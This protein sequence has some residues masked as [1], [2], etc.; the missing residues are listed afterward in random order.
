MTGRIALV[1]GATQGLGLAL[2][3]G[4]MHRLGSDDTVYLSGRDLAK[5]EAAAQ[6]ITGGAATLMAERLDVTDDRACSALSASLKARH[7]G[8]DIVISN[9][10]AR[11]A[12]GV[13]DRDQVRS[14]INT[15]NHGNRRMLAHFLPLLRK[16]GRFVTVASS[17]G[18]LRHLHPKL[19][20][21][22]S[23]ESQALDD[24][25]RVMDE[26]VDAV[27]NGRA[28]AEGWPAWINVPS[29]IGQVAS[30]KIAARIVREQRPSDGVL[31]NAACPGLVDTAASRPWFSDMSSAQSPD[32]A[33]IDVAWLALLPDGTVSPQG[34]LVQFRKILP[35]RWS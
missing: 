32:A 26:Y 3:Q 12:P 4:L 16:N 1:T 18:S 27:E 29:K 22:F 25:E 7:G 35:W 28:A 34:E 11:I 30:V 19:H 13:A 8:V 9:A 33:A 5:A 31:V 21:F 24:I 2:A 17:F 23:V 6:T 10:A 15:N 20:T 14:L